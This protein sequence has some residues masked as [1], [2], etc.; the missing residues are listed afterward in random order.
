MNGLI[1][2]AS[3]AYLI[4][5]TALLQYA[6]WVDNSRRKQVSTQA[7]L[8]RSN[9]AELSMCRIP[10]RPGARGEPG[11]REREPPHGRTGRGSARSRMRIVLREPIGGDAQS[12]YVRVFEGLAGGP[13]G[14]ANK[15][16]RCA[17]PYER[18]RRTMAGM[19]SDPSPHPGPL[20]DARLVQPQAQAQE[21]GEWK[22]AT[23]DG[24]CGTW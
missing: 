5:A 6:G 7:S 9:A 3:T 8:A 15:P 10:E 2:L 16:V 20:Y 4:S 18:R 13:L 1:A 11:R 24:P 14:G 17:A 23:W 19:T 21:V 12:R 22:I